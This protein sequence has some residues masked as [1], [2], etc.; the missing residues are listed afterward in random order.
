MRKKFVS[1]MAAFSLFGIASIPTSISHADSLRPNPIAEP[2]QVVGKY[3]EQYQFN[4]EKFSI[5]KLTGE[6]D[7]PYFYDFRN[8]KSVEELLK[9]TAVKYD[10]D[11][12]PM[13]KIGDTFYYHPVRTAQEALYYINSY[14]QLGKPE[15]L[16]K[17]KKLA[18][19]LVKLSL[20]PN[21]SL[22]FAYSFEY[23]V[24][25]RLE[26]KLNPPWYSGMSQGQALSVFTRLYEVTK[27]DKYLQWAD[28][29]FQSF[30]KINKS[31]SAEKP[32]VTATDTK[33][34]VWFEEYPTESNTQHVHVLNGFIFAI[35]GIYDY[36]LST[37]SLQA[38]N[39]LYGSLSTMLAYGDRFRLPGQ[40]SYYA[41]KY[42]NTAGNY[43][44]IHIRQLRQLNKMTTDSRF[45]DMA[46]RFYLDTAVT[47]SKNLKFVPYIPRKIASYFNEKEIQILMNEK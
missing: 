7:D 25:G 14:K 27:E 22:Y 36:Y 19:H 5:Q 11:G 10:Q 9:S 38:E 21:S 16:E 15:H 1:G 17:A 20:S 8:G 33:S 43:H 34:Y 31:I 18:A 3:N 29:T 30:L 4:M 44:N 24:L 40:Q 42:N 45:S 28:K 13:V 26:E 37:D 32:W 41:L 35:Y 47:K 12:M 46:D 39:F 2:S 23:K 6:K